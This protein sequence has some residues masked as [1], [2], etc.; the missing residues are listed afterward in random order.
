MKRCLIYPCTECDTGKKVVKRVIG[1]DNETE[2]S[3]SSD[4]LLHGSGKVIDGNKQPHSIGIWYGTNDTI[5]G[6]QMV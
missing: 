1:T 3:E 4:R 5:E 6:I 2:S